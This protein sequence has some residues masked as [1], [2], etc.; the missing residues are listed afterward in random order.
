MQRRDSAR[1]LAARIGT[2]TALALAIGFSP[3]AGAAPGGQK[4]VICTNPASGAKWEIRIDYDHHT[5]DSLPAEIGDAQISWHTVG[6]ENYKL[7]RKSGNLTVIVAS[8]TGGYFIHD[9]CKLDD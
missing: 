4:T 6:G 7:D 8:S 5:V 1:S 2:L 9:T 3:A